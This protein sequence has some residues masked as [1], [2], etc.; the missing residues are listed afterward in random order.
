ML[1]NKYVINVEMGVSINCIPLSQ[2]NNFKHDDVLWSPRNVQFLLNV[3]QFTKS[4]E[5][6][7]FG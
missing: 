1:H 6:N 7:L 5:G 3:K 4:V 2:S